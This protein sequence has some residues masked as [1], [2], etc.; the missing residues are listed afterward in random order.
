LLNSP[1]LLILD[2]P[3]NGLDPAGI[4]EMRDLLRRMSAEQGVTVFLSSH[5]LA[6]V[7]QVAELIGII[8]EGRMAFQGSLAELRLNQKSRLRVGVHDPSAAIGCLRAAG[9]T[10]RLDRSGFVIVD[11]RAGDAGT[12]NRLLV[13]NDHEILH[14]SF[15]Q[16]SLEDIFLS[17]TGGRSQ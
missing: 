10:A 3:T 11:A 4:Y 7:E 14:L 5:I 12:I 17:L 16:D 15:E 6:E 2:E 13:E 8:H 1:D 9:W